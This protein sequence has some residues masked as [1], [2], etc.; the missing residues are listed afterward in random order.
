MKPIYMMAGEKE[1]GKSLLT[2]AFLEY[3]IFQKCFLV[4]TDVENPDVYEAY[5]KKVPSAIIDLNSLMGWADLINICDVHSDKA[6]VINGSAAGIEGVERY[7]KILLNHL[8]FLKRHLVTFWMI[9]YE[10]RDLN[11][12]QRYRKIV[13][14]RIVHLVNNHLYCDVFD[15]PAYENS[16][17]KEELKKTG[18]VVYMYNSEEYKGH[19]FVF[20]TSCEVSFMDANSGLSQIVDIGDGYRV[21][22]RELADEIEGALPIDY[23]DYDDDYRMSD[24]DGDIGD[25]LAEGKISIED[26]AGEAAQ[27]GAREEE[28]DQ[29]NKLRL[30][31]EQRRA[32]EPETEEEY[33]QRAQQE[34]RNGGNPEGFIPCSKDIEE[35]ADQQFIEGLMPKGYVPTAKQLRKKELSDLGI[36]E[37]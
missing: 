20:D 7:G 31:K 27:E 25:L 9:T 14:R 21:F 32:L 33:Q 16:S 11:T 18:R 13:G 19:S 6:I 37:F 34:Y 2:A 5:S 4:D 24:W 12:L 30:E 3:L 1:S 29:R 28:L 35:K 17:I 36:L 8:F 10:T 15:V 26:L 22:T 23:D